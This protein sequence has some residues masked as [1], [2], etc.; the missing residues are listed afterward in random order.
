MEE[1]FSVPMEAIDEDLLDRIGRVYLGIGRL[2]LDERMALIKAL[3][4]RDKDEH[5]RSLLHP[6]AIL[7]GNDTLSKFMNYTL[8]NQ[9][10][11]LDKLDTTLIDHDPN[12][13]AY[14]SMR[15][16]LPPP[17]SDEEL[18]AY[19]LNP[20][21]ELDRYFVRASR[22][23]PDLKFLAEY[24]SENDKEP[25]ILDMIKSLEESKVAIP[26]PHNI[27]TFVK[28]VE[29]DAETFEHEFSAR[30]RYSLPLFP[31]I[32]PICRHKEPS[33]INI[34]TENAVTGNIGK[35]HFNDR[36]YS[37]YRFRAFFPDDGT[38]VCKFAFYNQCN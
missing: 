23:R 36:A 30:F 2:D 4:I 34:I 7:A 29:E 15:F 13:G 3:F 37:L 33:P 5:G 14:S 19:R 16:L 27:T 11:A 8:G 24:A 17:I 20:Q 12:N 26:H 21:A 31:K 18:S 35:Y 32:F 22:N 9:D 38:N 6:E 1:F 25:L 28:Q 10:I